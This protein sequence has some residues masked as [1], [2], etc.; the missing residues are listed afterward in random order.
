MIY[1]ILLFIFFSGTAIGSF[2]NAFE[3]RLHKKKD[4]IKDRSKCPRCGTVLRWFDLIPILSWLVLGG[5]CR[6]CGKKISVQYPLIELCTG[7]LFAVFAYQHFAFSNNFL[8]IEKFSLPYS[9][10]TFFLGLVIVSGLIFFTIYDLKYGI[11]PDKVLF[12]L[13]LITFF[14]YLLIYIFQLQGFLTEL[15]FSFWT[16]ILSAIGAGVFFFIIIFFTKGK[17]MGGGD[18]K[19]AIW[20]GLFLGWPN[21]LYALYTAFVV[22][23]FAGILL[24]ILKVKKLKETIPFGPFMTLSALTV[25]IYSDL[26]ERFS[27]EYLFFINFWKGLN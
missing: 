11:I 7:I 2:L 22:G 21:I 12:P 23:G 26:L 24:F 20:L 25:F 17:G 27:S 9:I 1:L 4:F 15:S 19:L 10:F 5:R 6:Y 16:N 14:S 8:V 18:M 13:I 3:F